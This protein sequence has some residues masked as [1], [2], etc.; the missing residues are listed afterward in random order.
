[1]HSGLEHDRQQWATLTDCNDI[2]Q[3]FYI[4]SQ[5]MPDDFR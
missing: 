5:S 3:T 2:I 1:M 4:L